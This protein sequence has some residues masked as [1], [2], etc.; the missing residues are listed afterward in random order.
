MKNLIVGLLLAGLLAG[1][2]ST[3]SEPVIPATKETVLPAAQPPAGFKTDIANV[4]GVNIHYVTG[5]QGEPLL[6]IHGFGQNWYMWNRL[7]PELSKH[8]TIIAPDLRGVGESGK[9]ESGYDK[10][11]MAADLHELV[12]KLGYTSVNV[13]GHD[14]GLMVAYAYAAQYG[15]EVK[16][17]AFLDALL[18]GVEPVWSNLKEKLWWFGFFAWP[19]SG[20]VV[21]GKEREFLSNFWPVV[22]HI[23]NAFTKEESE[24]FIRAYSVKGATT[25]AFHWFG[26][27]EQDA[28]DNLEFMKTKLKMP[29]LTMGGEYQ[30]A[31]FL[32]D[33]F[34]KVALDVKEIKIMDAGHWLVQEQTQPV[35]KGL[36]DFFMNKEQ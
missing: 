3:K 32:G 1:C 15:N 26:A 28:K 23:N 10:K 35:L 19:A 16:K 20:Q 11:T 25:G 29:V 9:P 7:L 34:K 31:P 33:H 18:P 17:A 6:L 5:G 36:M 22:G 13:A 8:F 2:K 21:E 30:S 27:F 4:N 12:K 24:E 14:I